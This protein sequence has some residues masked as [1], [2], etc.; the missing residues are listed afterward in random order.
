M[1]QVELVSRLHKIYACRKAVL[2]IKHNGFDLSQAW[3][4]CYEIHWLRWFIDAI[5]LTYDSFENC[6]DFRAQYT[7]EQVEKALIE[8]SDKTY[9]ER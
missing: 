1:E 6:D 8:E 3:N 9:N 5:G 7:L 4:Q 2:W